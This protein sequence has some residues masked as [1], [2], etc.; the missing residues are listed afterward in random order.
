MR[1][2]KLFLIGCLV[3]IPAL[4]FAD[5][6]YYLGASGVPSVSSGSIGQS[7]GTAAATSGSGRLYHSKDVPLSP[8][9]VQYAHVYLDNP[10][11]STVHMYLFSANGTQRAYCSIAIEGTT[12][13][14]YT[15][16]SAAPYTIVDATTYY[17][18]IGRTVADFSYGRTASGFT[19]L[20]YD[21]NTI[22]NDVTLNPEETVSD[23]DGNLS[24]R[25]D[26]IP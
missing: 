14:W 20:W 6:N 1:L 24:V 26:N 23:S 21:T 9:P 16:Q 7:T 2:F 12:A 10:N 22:D 15:C 8:G 18:G 17:Y 3:L 13:G 19:G 4:G 11:N 25:W 5:S